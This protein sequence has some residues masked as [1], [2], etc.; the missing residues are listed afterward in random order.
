MKHK[1][2]S[3][4]ISRIVELFSNDF[5]SPIAII[6]KTSSKELIDFSKLESI[7]LQIS[8]NSCEDNFILQKYI[9]PEF[10]VTVNIKFPLENIQ[11]HE[12]FPQEFKESL[13]GQSRRVAISLSSAY[14]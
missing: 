9:E 4:S 8:D 3:I 10:E 2:S 14:R 1:K 5:S 13:I 7:L 11:I 6:Y 12:D